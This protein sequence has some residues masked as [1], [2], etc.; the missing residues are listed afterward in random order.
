M[1]YVRGLRCFELSLGGVRLLAA[2]PELYV[3]KD[4]N[5]CGLG[6]SW[7]QRSVLLGFGDQLSSR[8][9]RFSNGFFT[10]KLRLFLKPPRHLRQALQSA[11][12]LREQAKQ[13]LLLARDPQQVL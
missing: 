6:A 10:G 2:S 13:L 12:L 9:K 3:D 1:S 11:L 4:S 8:T 5:R 7:F